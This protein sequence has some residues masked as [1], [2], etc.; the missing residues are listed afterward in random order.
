[1]V[2]CTLIRKQELQED[3][4]QNQSL[5]NGRNLNGQVH[6]GKNVT[7]NRTGTGIGLH[8]SFLVV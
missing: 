3:S 5:L 2:K 1:M 6:N 4:G 8:Q 7:H